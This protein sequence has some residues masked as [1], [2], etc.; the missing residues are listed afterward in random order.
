[1]TEEQR[2]TLINA[3][4]AIVAARTEYEE[5]HKD[6]GD[7]YAHMPRESWSK[8]DNDDLARFM[9]EHKIDAHG[10]EIDEVADLVLDNF[11]MRSEHMMS[12]HY[13]DRFTCGAYPIIEI[14][15]QIDL[16]ALSEQCGFTVTA[17]NIKALGNEPDCYI[18]STYEDSFLAYS[19]SDIVWIADISADTLRDALELIR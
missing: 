8:T 17:E 1:M 11:T 3:I 4:N 18:G 10:L 5:T 12:G 2:E 14:E 7:N 19:T 13:E 15:H 9:I 16:S 6:A